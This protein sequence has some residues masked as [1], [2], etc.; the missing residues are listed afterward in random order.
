LLLDIDYGATVR[1]LAWRPDTAEPLTTIESIPP[2]PGAPLD[3]FQI[4]FAPDYANSG[5]IELLHGANGAVYFSTDYGHTWERKTPGEPGACAR[6]PVSGFGALWHNNAEVR[7]LLGCPLK[8]EQAYAGAVQ[9]F[10]HGEL[11]HLA[12]TTADYDVTIYVLAPD[13]QGAT[14]WNTQPHYQIEA[15]PPP[16]PAGL[17][18]PAPIFHT[19]WLEGRCCQTDFQATQD[20][21]GWAIGPAE[22]LAAARQAFEGG[23][24][25]WREDRDQILVFQNNQRSSYLTFDD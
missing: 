21:L 8:D 13:G 4:T 10:E 12:F 22:T 1:V 18:E 16:A 23:T 6:E 19:A 17:L 7:E 11:L 2:A 9:P 24:L 20:V 15:T 5:K 25:I 3:Q 14:G